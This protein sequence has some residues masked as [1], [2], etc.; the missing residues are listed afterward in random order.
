MALP[1]MSLPKLSFGISLGILLAIAI[2]LTLALTPKGVAA[3]H[4]SVNTFTAGDYVIFSQARA[5]VAAETSN[6]GSNDIQASVSGSDN[7]IFGRI[8]SN[9]DFS[10]AGQNINYHFSNNGPIEPVQPN[11]VNDGKITYRFLN[12]NGDN[13]YRSPLSDPRYEAGEFINGTWLPVQS[14]VP[15]VGTVAPVSFDPAPVPEADPYQY[16]PGNLH[17]AV[18]PN[19]FYLEMDV[20]TLNDFC[21]FGSLIDGAEQEF[22]IKPVEDDPDTAIDEF[23]LTNGTYCTDGGLIKLSVQDVG[24]PEKPGEYTLLANDGLV[25]I[26]G[27]NAFVQPF[28]LNIL[29]MTDLDSDS[30]S[31]PIKISGSDFAVLED[32]ILFAPQ[33]GVDMSGSDGSLLCI[34]AVGQQVKVQGSNSSFGPQSPDCETL[35]IDVTKTATPDTASSAGQLIT[36]DYVVTNNGNVD[37]FD[38]I[39]DD[40]IEGL[41]TLIGLID[42]DEDGFLDDLAP[43]QVVTGTTT[44]TMTQQEIDLAT[45]TNIGEVTGI[46]ASDIEVT[47]N[48]AETVTAIHTV[49]IGIVKTNT[50][51][52]DEDDSGDISLNDTLTYE[53]VVTNNGN[54]T[55]TNVAVTDPLPGLSAISG[56]V[57]T[58]APKASTTFTATYKVTQDDVDAGTIANTA[59]ATGTPPTPAGGTPPDPITISDDEDVV[60]PQN[61]N[62]VVE[63]TPDITINGAPVNAVLLD[64]ITF[65][66]TVTNSGNVTLENLVLTDD[67]ESPVIPIPFDTVVGGFIAGD[68]DQDGNLDL[69][70]TWTAT[71]DHSVTQADLDAGQI[72]TDGSAGE[73]GTA[74]VIATGATDTDP[75]GVLLAQ[76]PVIEVLKTAD[77]ASVAAPGTITYSYDV[78]NGGNV[79]LSNVTLG[80]NNTDAPPVFDSID[81]SN[82]GDTDGDNELDVGETWSYTATHTVSQAE[83]DSG[84]SIVNLATADSN[85]SEPDTGTVTVTVTQNPG[86]VV[87]KTPDITINS[88]A[89]N[90]VL[91]DDIAFT[92]TVTNSGNVTLENPVLTDDL[93]SPL[94]PIP[95]DTVVG[96]SIAGDTNQDGKLDLGETWTATVDHSVTQ[97]DLDAG[98]IGTDGSAGELGTATVVANGATDTDP[99]GVLLAQN[100][101]IEVLKTADVASVAAPG[102]ITYSYDV[103]NGGN[104]SLSNVTL[105]DNNTNAAPVF[106]SVNGSNTGDTDGDDELDV[107]ETWSY[108]A[109][110]TV[111]QADIDS[112]A[113]IVNLATAN[114]TESEPDTGTVTVTVTQNPGIVVQKTPDITTNSTAVNAVLLQDITF[115]Y[116]VTNSGNVTLENLVLTD[117]LESPLLP[118]PFDTVAGGGFIAGDTDLDGKLD[119]GETWT[120]TA[121]HSVTQADL[122]AGQI[123]TDGALA[124]ELGTATVTATGALDTDPG[125]VLLAQNPSILLTKTGT[126]TDADSDAV[127]EP[128]AG[129]GDGFGQPGEQITYAFTVTNNGNVTLTAV[130]LEDT[131]TGVTISSI[132]DLADDD[133][134]FPATILGGD[135]ITIVNL[136]PGAIETATGSYALLQEDIDAREKFNAASATGTP[137]TPTTGNPATAPIATDDDTVPVPQNASIQLIKSGTFTDADSDGVFEP[138]AGEGDGFGQPGEQ[139][140]YTF[141]VTNNGNVPLTNVTLTDTATGVI[142]SGSPIA[143]LAPGASD[144]TSITGTYTLLQGDI[145]AREKFN[146]ASVTGTP[147]TPTNGAPAAAPIATDDDTVPV[148]QN[149]SILLTKSGTFTDAD[150]DGVFEPLAGEG[151]G[152]GQPGEQITYTFTVTN[153]GNVP[154]T[155]VTLTD[156]ATGVIISGSPIASLA[157]GA[158]DSTSI[159]GTYTLLQGDIDAREKFNAASVTGTPPTPTTGA[160]AAAPIAT[161]DDLAPGASDGAGAPERLDTAEQVGHLHRRQR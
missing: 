161:D 142:I 59:T 128:L 53:F 86:I 24:T 110:Y 15:A 99:G 26:S 136:A 75:G 150:S 37:L 14:H 1:T 146:A 7:S 94:L 116:T 82:T 38:V 96:G 140:T 17:L 121:D 39:L 28:E 134:V 73:L 54:S 71:A 43:L 91:L 145:D 153:N 48:D 57:S 115:T 52:A 72:G 23:A 45:V 80:D 78:T 152:F 143:S 65:T 87:Q 27:Q 88:T 112:G 42:L 60:V 49:G 4:G 47:D 156:T 129:E 79:S 50:A 155:N 16:W 58:L 55:L 100:P 64:D 154:L 135:P 40:D 123:G 46:S 106:D 13:F 138:L 8:R 130:T 102:T 12:T 122:D 127:D 118:I 63:K 104:V 137:P 6:N 76:N 126:F 131:T 108:T 67:L 101:V 81:G 9:A 44:H 90:A 109:T 51:N 22:D 19:S 3:D 97:A 105:G 35:G 132:S 98:Q 2:A 41:I 103:T 119:L 5:G 10:S 158:S 151:D 159:T 20:A 32:A 107:G 84:A 70:E 117:D 125:G 141:T 149:A 92:Y 83:I 93:E 21:D 157:P 95:F 69:G 34:H 31:F 36:Y 111:S 139:I 29:A 85:E 89:V 25:T 148:P 30:D 77:V 11:V 33:S 68:T 66:Y 114:S 160:P 147:P 74:T 144:S 62:I 120:A 124:G 61:P 18:I 133:E 113:S 56:G